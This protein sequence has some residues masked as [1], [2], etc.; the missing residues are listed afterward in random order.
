MS[1]DLKRL[2]HSKPCYV[3]TPR[4]VANHPEANG[5]PLHASN[6]MEPTVPLE[7]VLNYW[8]Y[9]PSDRS[10]YAPAAAAIRPFFFSIGSTLGSR[11]LKRRYASEGSTLLPVL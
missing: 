1:Q 7:V 3:V 4:D 2:I 9:S 11:P 8:G 10:F 6:S 5:K